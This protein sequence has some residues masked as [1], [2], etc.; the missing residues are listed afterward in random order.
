MNNF[1]EFGLSSGLLRALGAMNYSKP[2]PIQAAAIPVGL[3]GRDLIGCAQTGTGKTAAF[4]I[5]MITALNKVPGKTSLIL[6][7]TREL[8]AQIVGV[9]DQLCNFQQSQLR[10]ALLIG[11]VPIARQT[12]ALSRHPRIIVATPGRLLD[13]L[14]QRTLSLSEVQILVLDEADRMLDMGFEP[15]LRQILRHLPRERQTMLFSATIP[16][17]ILSLASK[18]L[19]DPVRVN[20]GPLSRPVDQVEQQVRRTTH[21]GKNDALVSELASRQGSV[22]VFA[23]TKARTDRVARMLNRLGHDVDRI[24]G[25]RTQSQRTK[26]IEGFRAGKFRILVATDIAA[27]GLDIPHIEHVINYDLP[28]CPED[29]IHRIGRT[30]RAGATGFALAFVTPEDEDQWRQINRLA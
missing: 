12:G 21:A 20:A 3:T 18:F 6:A 9:I 28:Q 30:A 10:T 8:A 14:Q 11:G 29:Y 19:K 13:H 25:D 24:H 5:P 26:A 4:S 1:K 27:R 7:P 16:A 22:L 23:R 2:T 15:Q 17:E